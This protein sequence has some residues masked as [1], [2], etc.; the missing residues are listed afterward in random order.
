MT[1]NIK[2]LKYPFEF[3]EGK[4][5][6]NAI[7]Y[8]ETHGMALVCVTNDEAKVPGFVTLQQV[9]FNVTNDAAVA[10][11]VES[12]EETAEE[13]IEEDSDEAP[14]EGPIEEEIAVN[15]IPKPSIFAGVK[16]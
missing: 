16:S 15:P 9:N 2:S 11:A 1:A 13:P 7:V 5:I 6:C 14:T 10:E 3:A 12:V 4:L 8:H